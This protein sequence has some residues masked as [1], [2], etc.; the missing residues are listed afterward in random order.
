MFKHKN[1]KY[2]KVRG[3][4][5]IFLEIHCSQCEG[6]VLIYQ[7][8]GDGAL[9]R[10]YLNRIF[11]PPEYERLQYQAGLRLK[12]IPNLKCPHCHQ[13]IGT[14]MIHNDGRFAFRLKPGSFKK[15]VLKKEV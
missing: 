13:L 12:E 6:A 9:M 7:K 4:K 1:D 14:P 3:G 10:C 2:R 11:S 5:S 15:Q 8:D